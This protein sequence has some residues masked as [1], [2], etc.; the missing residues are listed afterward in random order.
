M[1]KVIYLLA[2]AAVV[3][4]AAACNKA[5]SVEDDTVEASFNVN[6]EQLATKAQFSDGT[7][8]TQ[9]QV[10]VYTD[11]EY[12]PNVSKLSE[13]INITATVNL[14][15]V[16][17][18]T[19]DIVFWAQN[20]AGPYTVAPAAATMT[21][22]P[23]GN[24]NDE[25]RDAFYRLYNTGKVTG[26]IEKTIEL[27]R[28]FAQINVF[29]TE[30]DYNAAKDSKVN[31]SESGMKLQ[32]PTVLHLLTGVA[33][34]PKDYVFNHAAINVDEATR[35]AGYKYV[36]MNYV[37][38]NAAAELTAV[39]FSVWT[40]SPAVLLNEDLNVTSVP[41]RRNYK[42]NIMGNIFTVDG[43]FN[44]EI[45]PAYETPDYQKEF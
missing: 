25:N 8:A 6:L 7:S 43:K 30:A 41:Y 40:D 16:K 44:V 31:F 3:F 2:S 36:A 21:V 4:M 19:Y 10:L 33:D 27:K 5:A 14:K 22:A 23:T 39:N 24:A 18:K 28:P 9:L 11:G 12:L 37:L 29:T 42:T 20:A 35:L 26:P 32:A 34:T 38:A 15:L 13:T 17:G 1:K 45:K